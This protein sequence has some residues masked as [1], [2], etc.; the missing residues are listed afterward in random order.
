VT[1]DGHFEIFSLAWVMVRKTHPKT[2]TGKPWTDPGPAKESWK[3]DGNRYSACEV[4]AIESSL[5]VNIPRR[6]R[7]TPFHG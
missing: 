1:K 3:S 7:R 4:K 2:E 6:V 5:K